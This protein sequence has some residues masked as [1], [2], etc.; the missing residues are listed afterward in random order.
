MSKQIKNL[1][2]FK[3]LSYKQGGLDC[4]IAL[5]GGLRSSKH[6]AFDG[7]TFFIDNLIDGTEQKLKEKELFH[8]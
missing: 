7:I 5:N 4:F 1:S 2:H 8:P 6:I 3:C